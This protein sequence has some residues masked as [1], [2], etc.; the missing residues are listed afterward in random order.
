MHP[1]SLPSRAEHAGDRQAQPVMSIRDHQL[2]A[3]QSA[4]DQ[5]LDKPRPE[6]LGFGR[7]YAEADDLTL[8]LDIDGDGD[9]R[10]HGDDAAAIAHLQVGGVQ[11]EIRPLALDRPVKEGV[12][13]LIDVFAELG[14]LALRDAGEAHRLH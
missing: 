2:D 10:R 8:S 1:T 6:R 7:T 3:A 5:A 4:L 13:P 11:P 9:Y 14:N 12:D